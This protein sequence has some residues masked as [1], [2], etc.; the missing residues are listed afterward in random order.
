MATTDD[1]V[2]VYSF[3]HEHQA[4]R[5][6]AIK[7]REAID[8]PEAKFL[9]TAGNWNQELVKDITTAYRNAQRAMSDINEGLQQHFQHEEA[10]MP[11]LI[12]N[13]LTKAL[14]QEHGELLDK[15]TEAR[16]L[17]NQSN[18][19]QLSREELLARSYDIRNSAISIF[20]QI[21]SH[22]GKEDVILQLLRIASTQS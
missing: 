14:A 16:I 10:S 21:E 1:L 12:G 17:V 8:K 15:F 2:T 20:D 11:S 3:L 7:I 19:E 9:Q 22:I 4:I 13:L 18:L 5:Q 6:N